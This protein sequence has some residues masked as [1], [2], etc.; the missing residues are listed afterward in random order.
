MNTCGSAGKFYSVRVTGVL[1]VLLFLLI[2]LPTRLSL[3]TRDKTAA[4]E[5]V[6]PKVQN[7]A[8]TSSGNKDWPGKSQQAIVRGDKIA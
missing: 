1:A 5:G 3:F 7:T 6:M 4:V 2:N 8:K